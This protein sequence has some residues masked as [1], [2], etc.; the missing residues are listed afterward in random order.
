MK[1]FT[2]PVVNDHVK[3]CERRYR[4]P[5]WDDGTEKK[6]RIVKSDPDFGMIL[7]RFPSLGLVRTSYGF[8]YD[9]STITRRVRLL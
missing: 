3:N 1:Y 7:H 2:R 6:G 5:L 8:V 9:L 4:V